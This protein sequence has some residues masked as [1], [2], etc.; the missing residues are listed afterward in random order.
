MRAGLARPVHAAA[1]GA[2]HFGAW[3]LS[4]TVRRGTVVK[5]VQTIRGAL[6]AGLVALGG[7]ASSLVGL[8]SDGTY[9]LERGELSSSCDAMHRNFNTRVEIL[10]GLPARAKAEREAVPTTAWSMVGRWL[11]SPN[12]GLNA[13]N[14][15]DRE[16]AHAL[17]V[18]RAMR[19]K[20]CQPVD[21]DRELA[22]AD[23]EIR[24]IR[25]N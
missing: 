16:R 5:S 9:I 19:E 13:I 18:Q 23:A 21:L 25:S 12:K 14:D 6:L 15:Y 7:C 1:F 20:Q 8:Q 24:R 17:A 10:K 2:P 22:E 11:S 3:I 4:I